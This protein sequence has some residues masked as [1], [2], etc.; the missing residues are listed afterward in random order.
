MEQ[1]LAEILVGAAA[2]AALS[3]LLK[4]AGII[5]WWLGVL[6]YCSIVSSD[7]MIVENRFGLL[8]VT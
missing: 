7:S 2:G 4:W 1:L 5:K 6:V 8:G 3:A